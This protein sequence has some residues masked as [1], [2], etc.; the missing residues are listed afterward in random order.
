MCNSLMR[1]RQQLL[2]LSLPP[3]ANYANYSHQGKLRRGAS[4][5]VESHSSLARLR[6][7]HSVCCMRL[8]SC[9]YKSNILRYIMDYQGELPAAGIS[10]NVDPYFF[11]YTQFG[12]YIVGAIS[13][14]SICAAA[15]E[16]GFLNCAYTMCYFKTHHPRKPPN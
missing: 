11:S 10:K 9:W 1:S 2:G 6:M 5:K 15:N 13:F 16:G 12:W 7:R 4:H 14:G 3:T 8:V